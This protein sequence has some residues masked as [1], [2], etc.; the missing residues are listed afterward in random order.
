MGIGEHA[1]AGDKRETGDAGNKR[2]LSQISL[3]SDRERLGTRQGLQLCFTI[4][5]RA[6]IVDL[7]IRLK[8]N[9]RRISGN[10]LSPLG[11]QFPEYG[12]RRCFADVTNRG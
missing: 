12:Y 4:G 8:G 10:S 6:M 7:P 5:V 9:S 1:R 3:K 2:A 11:A